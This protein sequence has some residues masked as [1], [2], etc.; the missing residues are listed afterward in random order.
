MKNFVVNV[1]IAIFFVPGIALCLV[2]L[3]GFLL[4]LWPLLSVWVFIDRMNLESN[5]EDR[6]SKSD[7]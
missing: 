6:E 1:F 7:V 4:L 3:A 5:R 2:L